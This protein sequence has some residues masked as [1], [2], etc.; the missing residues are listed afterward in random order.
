MDGIQRHADKHVL[1]LAAT[2]RREVLDPAVLRPGRL[3]VHI[4]VPLPSVQ[5]L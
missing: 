4:H 2:N 3:D 1:V 5:V